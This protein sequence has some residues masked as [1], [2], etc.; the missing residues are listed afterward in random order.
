VP[1]IYYGDEIGMEGR[2]DPDNRRCMIWDEGQW[3]QDLR[4]YYQRLIHLRRTAPALR[5][6]GFQMLY[7]EGDLLAYQR[8]SAEQR[9]VVVANRGNDAPTEVSLTVHHA[10]IADGTTLTDYLSGQTFTVEQGQL[11]LGE[12]AAGRVLLLEGQ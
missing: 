4:G 3:D 9:I 6:G 1:C 7:A 8:Q 2:R 10:G 11:H 5:H 12:F